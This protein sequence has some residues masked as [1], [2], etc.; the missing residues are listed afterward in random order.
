MNKTNS[1]NLAYHQT[2]ATL[3]PHASGT[4][5]VE[6]PIVLC[7]AALPCTMPSVDQ[8]PKVQAYACRKMI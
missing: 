6:P 2:R 4:V 8:N 1:S 7:M 5:F 3:F